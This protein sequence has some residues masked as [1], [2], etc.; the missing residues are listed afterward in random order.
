MHK[1]EQS[2][3]PHPCPHCI[4]QYIYISLDEMRAVANFLT[5]KGRVAISELANKSSTFIDLEA[6][7]AAPDAIPGGKAGAISFDSLI[8]DEPAAA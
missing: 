7:Q 1:C 3:S 2:L 4:S 8:D 5:T 6:K